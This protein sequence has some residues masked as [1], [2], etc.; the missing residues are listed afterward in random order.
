M[1]TTL[2]HEDLLIKLRGKLNDGK[3]KL[4]EP[5]FSNSSDVLSESLQELAKKYAVDLSLDQEMVLNALRELQLHSMERVKANDEFKETGLATFRIKVTAP[6]EKPGMLKIQKM[7]TSPGSDLISAVATEVGIEESRLKIICN[8]KIIKPNLSLM[9]QNLKN[10]TLLMAL[11]LDTTPEEVRKEEDMYNQMK[12]T[13]DD[14]TLLSEYVNKVA[15]GDEYIKLED[16]S[17]KTV[18][19]PKAERKS[20]L[21]GLALHERGRAAIKQKDYSLALIL[22]LEADRQFSECR[23]SLLQTVDNWGILQLDIAWCYAG[24][25][26]VGGAADAARRLEAAERALSNSYGRDQQRLLQ[27][28]GTA[29]N[30]RVLLMRLYLLQGIVAFHQNRR[31]EARSLLEKAESELNTLRVDEE[32]VG[33]LMELGW[34]R[35]QARLGLRG[36][37]GD[38]DRAHLQ[39]AA[40]AEQRAQARERHRRERQL[41]LLGECADGTPVDPSGVRSLVE[42]GFPRGRAVRALRLANNSV[43]DA[44]TTLQQRVELLED[45]LGSGSSTGSSEEAP[46]AQI[47]QKLVA[48]LESMGYNIEEVKAVLKM[49]NYHVETAVEMLMAKEDPFS[50]DDAAKPSTSSGG[51]ARSKLKQER[52]IKR[53]ERDLALQRLSKAI[54]TDEDDYL[55]TSLLEEEQY[56]AEYKSLL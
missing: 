39:L 33:R 21:V 4:W 27:V 6:K 45:A 20:L 52:E 34:S 17:G 26:S 51:A 1:E 12:T 16:Q 10:G 8:G 37:A 22:L 38:P 31:A 54:R 42:M 2:Q 43:A 15:D 13:R 50:D 32:A 35:T 5:P 53:K 7:L 36:A 47:D 24:L 28:K 29:A 55:D 19:L 18:E 25:R 40:L 48:E 9:E 44:V 56:L 11:V 30:E 46:P 23:S 14:A 49:C 41:R 3:I